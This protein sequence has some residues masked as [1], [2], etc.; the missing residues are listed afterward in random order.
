MYIYIHTPIYR[1]PHMYT[2]IYMHPQRPE[3]T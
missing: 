3:Y 1:Y 2:Y